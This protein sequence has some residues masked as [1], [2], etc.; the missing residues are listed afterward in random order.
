MVALTKSL[1]LLVEILHDL[2]KREDI[3]IYHN[4]NIDKYETKIKDIISTLSKEV[5]IALLSE[6]EHIFKYYS[7]ELRTDPDFYR[8]YISHYYIYDINNYEFKNMNIE[9]IRS[10]NKL[11][12]IFIE[13][14]GDKY[15][16]YFPKDIL[17]K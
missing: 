13:K 15:N 12:D 11:I 6:N 10:N 17:R 7:L 1:L 14:Y 8:A 5:L 16:D 2:N 4:E 3:Y 9:L